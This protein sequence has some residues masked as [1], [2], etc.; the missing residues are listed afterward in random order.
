MLD[1]RLRPEAHGY[2]CRVGRPGRGDDGVLGSAIGRRGRV[3]ACVNVVYDVVTRLTQC[4][5]WC[6]EQWG[7]PRGTWTLSAAGGSAR[8]DHCDGRRR[9]TWLLRVRRT[10]SPCSR[11]MMGAQPFSAPWK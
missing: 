3:T 9:W 11:A 6:G 5:M 4:A 7:W 8:K 2:T 10:L 1:K